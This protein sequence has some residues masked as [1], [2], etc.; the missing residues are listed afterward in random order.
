M[1][2]ASSPNR[3]AHQ[4]QQG[5]Q[6]PLYNLN[7]DEVHSHLG[8]TAGRPMH[9]MHVDELLKNVISSAEIVP[10]TSNSFPL[11]GLNGTTFSD[12]KSMNEMWREMVQQQQFKRSIEN[13]NDN[14]HLQLQLQHSSLVGEIEDYFVPPP[15]PNHATT[16]VGNHH[17]IVIGD[18]QPLMPIEPMAMASQPLQDWLPMPMQM[19]MTMP[20]QM[21]LPAINIHQQDISASSESVVYENPVFEMGYAENS[22][23]VVASMSSTSSNTKG[24]VGLVGRKR[25]SSDELM[26]K[27]IERRQK[28]MAKNRESAA[29]SRAKKQAY[30]NKLEADK[31]RLLRTN[32][33][34]RKWKVG[35]SGSDIR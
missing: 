32:A 26:E 21:Q 31:E 10:N 23:L 9:N 4:G 3:A 29:K 27:T 28:R 1:D 2:M 20:M 11:G 33:S 30:I 14:N 13:S 17:D 5:P 24:G 35:T 25:M 12:N 22:S 16:I 18:A 7:F 8:H 19:A 6:Y 34:I 15:P